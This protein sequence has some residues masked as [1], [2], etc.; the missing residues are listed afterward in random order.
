MSL[1]KTQ[2][3][4]YI[5]LNKTITNLLDSLDGKLNLKSIFEGIKLDNLD[6]F[7]LNIAVDYHDLLKLQGIR[8][9]IKD[10][11]ITFSLDGKFQNFIKIYNF[12]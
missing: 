8:V 5:L 7:L 2:K 10:I 9:N 11:A 1:L 4:N 12:V 3:W 6:F